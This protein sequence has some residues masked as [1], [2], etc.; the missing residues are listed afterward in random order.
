MNLLSDIQNAAGTMLIMVLV[1]M[2]IG[3]LYAGRSLLLGVFKKDDRRKDGYV[4]AYQARKAR[5]K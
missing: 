4:N 5:G 2:L 1:G 3:L